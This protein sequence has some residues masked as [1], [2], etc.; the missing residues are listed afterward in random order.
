MVGDKGAATSGSQTGASGVKTPGSAKRVSPFRLALIISMSVLVCETVVMYGLHL[1]APFAGMWTETILDA[2]LLTTMILPV[3]YFFHFTP[4]MKNMANLE[5]TESALAEKSAYLDSILRSSTD[6]A[7][8]ATD[9]DFHITY[10]NQ[11]AEKIFGYTAEEVIGRTVMEI[12]TKEKVDHS[13]FERAMEKVRKDG[14]YHYKLIHEKEGGARHLES[15]VSGIWDKSGALTGFVLMSRDVTERQK[16]EE[17]LKESHERLLTALNSLDAAIF[18]EDMA[19]HEIIFTNRRLGELFGDITGKPCWRT[20]HA[21]GG[22]TCV[23]C[24]D[25]HL[26]VGTGRAWEFRNVINNRWYDVRDR[27]IQWVD[28]RVV[29]LEIATDITE[30]K[31]SEE[32]SRKL[33]AKVLQTQKLESLGLLA[34]GIAHDFNNLLVGILGNADLALT[35]LPNVSPA[36]ESVREIENAAMRASDLCRQLLAY[37]GKGKF[38]I[39]PFN[40]NEVVEEMTHLLEVSKSKNVTIRYDFTSDLPSIEGDITQIRQVIMNLITNASEAIGGKSGVIT[41][42]TGVM[43]CDLAYLR[44][45]VMDETLPEGRYVFL[46]ISDTGVGM[47]EDTKSR[48]FDP[49]FST[50]FSGRGLGLAAALGIVRGH[51]GALKVY[52]EP[53]KGTT[54]KA[55][56]PA[57]DKEARPLARSGAQYDF[58][59]SGLIMLVD[60]DEGVRNVGKRQLAKLGFDVITAASGAKALEIYAR[61]H[62]EI[63]LVIL[64]LTMPDMDGT[65]TFRELKRINPSARVAL[66][67]GYNEQESINR[68]TGKGLAGF[69]QKPYRLADLSARIKEIMGTSFSG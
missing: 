65:E 51:K 31:M 6:M 20:I 69:I 55:I 64:D 66:T 17:A 9:L 61:R 37:S 59:G 18:V 7:I 47:D 4:L 5:R 46:E 39:E 52:S 35:E 14:E 34:G 63:S 38:V 13:R 62:G 12:H 45:M 50:K 57:V 53:G 33:E 56:F 28:G 68:F 24:A 25:D 48:I 19:T 58:A 32:K 1:F 41:I 42:S 21:G 43:E 30:R 54:F 11:V 23:H 49:F 2:I 60:D 27:A 44:E 40:L 15:R 22:E 29:K 36:R 10:Y 8:A 16:T 67:S 3:L 26:L